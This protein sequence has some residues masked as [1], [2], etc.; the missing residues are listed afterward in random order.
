MF[1]L[2]IQITQVL[3]HMFGNDT[4]VSH[5]KQMKKIFSG[6]ISLPILS[7]EFKHGIQIWSFNK[8]YGD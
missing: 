3:K 5:L 2:S 4:N 8:G 1:I 7:V 6:L